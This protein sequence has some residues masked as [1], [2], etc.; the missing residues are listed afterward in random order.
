MRLLN[1]IFNFKGKDEIW[2]LQLVLDFNRIVAVKVKDI[3]RTNILTLISLII[4]AAHGRDMTIFV[5]L[6]YFKQLR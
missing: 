5:H 3:Y 1:E 6:S 4:D 2:F